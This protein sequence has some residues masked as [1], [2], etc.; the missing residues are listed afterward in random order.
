[1]AKPEDLRPEDRALFEKVKLEGVGL[2]SRC[3]WVA[4]CASCDE[5]KAWGFACRRTLWAAAAEAVRPEKKPRGRPAK[6]K[7]KK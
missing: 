6:A 4:G 7:A 5:G 3:R 1:M 2:C